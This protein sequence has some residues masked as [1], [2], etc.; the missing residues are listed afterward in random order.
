MSFRKCVFWLHLTAGLVVGVVVLVMSVTGVLLTYQR[1][2]TAWADRGYRS[3]PPTAG[4]SRLPVSTLAESVAQAQ[5]A[6]APSAVTIESDPEAPAVVRFGRRPALYVNPYTGQVLGEGSQR[7]RA[8]FRGVTDWHRWLATSG[9]NRSVG[10]AVTGAANL[11]FLFLVVSGFYLWWPRSWRPG[12]LRAVVWF[13]GGLRGKARDWNWHNVIGF[14]CAAPLFVVVLSGVMISYPWATNLVYRIVG[15]EPPAQ[16]GRD[17]GAPAAGAGASA[18]RPSGAGSPAPGAPRGEPGTRAEGE[19]GHRNGGETAA[20]KS[21]ELASTLAGIDAAI[22]VAS[23]HAPSW[24]S[25]TVQVPASATAPIVLSIDEGD[26]GQPQ[27]RGTLT[28][29]RTTG[30]VAKWEPFASLSAGRRLRSILRFAH[31]GEVAGLLGQTIAGLVSAGAAVLVW[32]GSALS[33][34]RFVGRRDAEASTANPRS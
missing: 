34:R 7:V 21:V 5:S 9:E 23:K 25:L 27:R 8:L 15:D 26:G 11:G 20:A 13:K 14:W 3:A 16:G 29:D 10:K 22:D 1:Q 17:G 18:T 24:R 6:G 32:T 12:V 28:V 30:A 19:G 4:Q 33:Y 31:T 2:M